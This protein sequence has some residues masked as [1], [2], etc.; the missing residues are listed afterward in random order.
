MMDPGV[1][2]KKQQMEL[3]D[4]ESGGLPVERQDS[5]FREAVRAEHAGAAHWDEQV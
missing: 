5:L 4:V 3:V 1:E 2:K